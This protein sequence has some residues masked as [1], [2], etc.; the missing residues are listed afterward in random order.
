MKDKPRFETEPS[1]KE[2]FKYHTSLCQFVADELIDIVDQD[3]KQLK[4][5]KYKSEAHKKGYWH[6]TVQIW[7]YTHSGKI[8]LQLRK[9][10]KQVY[11]SLWDISVGGHVGSGESAILAA[12]REIKEEISVDVHET[13]L[14]FLKIFKNSVR[15]NDVIDNEF[16]YTYL[17]KIHNSMDDLQYQEDEIEKLRFIEI[18]ELIS[19]LKTNSERYCPHPFWLEILSEI[20]K[21]IPK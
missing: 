7:V 6:R 3:N 9:S 15:Y 16:N 4:F 2:C 8:L 1:E 11:P 21:R 10:T 5:E 14:H 12:I 17:L 20:I 19:E 13:S 18:D